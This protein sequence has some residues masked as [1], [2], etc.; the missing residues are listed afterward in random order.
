G[1]Q[2]EGYS[3]PTQRLACQHKAESLDAT[4]IEEFVDAGESARSADRPQL[5]RLLQFIQDESVD[6]L[7]VH[8][9]DRLARNRLDD[10]MISVA[11]DQAGVTLVS[12]SEAI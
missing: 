5:Q 3:I 9:I 10:L 6:Y 4:V 7:I 12:C 1:G 11:L 8:K 2:L